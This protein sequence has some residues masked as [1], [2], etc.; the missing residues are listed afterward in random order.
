M[1]QGCSFGSIVESF[2]KSS[3]D[4]LPVLDSKGFLKGLITLNDI[5]IKLGDKSYYENLKGKDL[6]HPPDITVDINESAYEALK[7]FDNYTGGL[8]PVVFKGNWQE[9]YPK[10]NY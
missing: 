6:I 9:L 10:I 2:S 4:I 5:R 3:H 8:L 1:T 7:K